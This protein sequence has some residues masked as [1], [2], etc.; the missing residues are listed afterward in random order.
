MSRGAFKSG[1]AIYAKCLQ[2]LGFPSFRFDRDEQ[3]YYH[4]RLMSARV[5]I[6]SLEFAQ[7]QRELRGT[8]P[9][10]GLM[11]LRDFLRDSAGSVE[12]VVTGGSDAEH[13]PVLALSVSG[14]LHMQCQR[15]L[16]QLDYPLRYSTTL[17]LVH[18]GEDLSKTVADPEAADAVEASAELDV[19]ELI[20]DE[21]LL[22]LP[23]SPRHAEGACDSRIKAS[24]STAEGGTFSGLAALKNVLNRKL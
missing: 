23:F 8:L 14:V 12:F 16:E 15:C 17:R 11:R 13:R 10:S 19:A 20:E 2:S 22:S 4:A 7:A 5:V 18:P 24:G 3:K 1:Q 9:V 6:D 21:I